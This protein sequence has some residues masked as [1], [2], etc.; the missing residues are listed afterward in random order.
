MFK[1]AAEGCRSPRRWRDSKTF[2]AM[3]EPTSGEIRGEIAGEFDEFK[4][5]NQAAET[6]TG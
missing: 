3:R 1:K 5:F 4:I 6:E 2:S